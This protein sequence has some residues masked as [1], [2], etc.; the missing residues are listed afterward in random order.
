MTTLSQNTIDNTPEMFLQ[1]LDNGATEIVIP[2]SLWAENK[3]RIML[4]RIEDLG[5]GELYAKLKF[6]MAIDG[7]GNLQALENGNEKPNWCKGW[8]SGSLPFH[9]LIAMGILKGTEEQFLKEHA[10]YWANPELDMYSADY[11]G[12]RLYL[13]AENDNAYFAFTMVERPRK[14]GVM[15]PGIENPHWDG[16][17]IAG[18]GV[19]QRSSFGNFK[20]PAA[21][22]PSKAV[23]S[24]PH[25]GESVEA[26]EPVVTAGNARTRSY[27]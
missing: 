5:N 12:T 18:R 1:Q 4:E 15:V 24:K 26:V 17:K 6:V 13:T 23:V 2:A 7:E 3:I 27:M 8:Y 19:R 16:M 10:A 25:A 11:V 14:D 22:K 20:R 9:E 21:A